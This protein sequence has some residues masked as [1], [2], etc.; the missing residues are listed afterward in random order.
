M[1]TRLNDL[2]IKKLSKTFEPDSLLEMKFKGYDIAFRTDEEGNPVQVFFG[3][4]TEDG[5]IKGERYRRTLK[6]DK[7][8]NII[9]DH[10]E[11]KGKAS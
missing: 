8:G 11:M 10:W 3:R 4:K 9:K 5:S 2:L 6:K 7:D 1:K